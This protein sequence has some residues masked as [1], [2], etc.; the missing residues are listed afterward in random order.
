MLGGKATEERGV[1]LKEI[2]KSFKV[3]HVIFLVLESVYI[4]HQEG[5]E[6]LCTVIEILV[7]GLCCLPGVC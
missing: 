1:I 4:R 5:G 3:M 7:I 6:F 2:L